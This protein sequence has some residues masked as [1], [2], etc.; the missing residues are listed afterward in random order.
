MVGATLACA[1][2]G[3]S[4]KVGVIEPQI[5]LPVQTQPDSRVSAITPAS[6]TVFEN[7]GAWIGINAARCGTIEAMHIWEGDSAVHFDSAEIGEPCLGWIVENRL[8]VSTLQERLQQ[9]SNIS[10]FCPAKLDQ[11]EIADKEVTVKLA[12]GR[13]L[14]AALLVGAD[15]ASSQVR[16]AVGIAWTSHDLAQAAI[17]ATLQT[18]QVHAGTARQRFLP[19]GPLA[20]LPLADPHHVSIVWSA[21][22]ALAH[23]LMVLD[24]AGFT[25][26]L[27]SAFG[28]S[29]GALRL[30]SERVVIPLTLGFAH[31]Y[32]SHRVALI[33]DAAHTVHPLAGQGVNL[34]I[35]D[36]ATLAEILLA[37]AVRRRDLGG[38]SLLRRYERARKGADLGMQLLT[39][40][41]RYLFGSNL[42]GSGRLRATGLGLSER[43]PVLKNFLMRRASGLGGELP[44]LAQRR[45]G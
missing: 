4:L 34:G 14:R 24:V 7:I 41:L 31:D 16:R 17:V 18:E 35:L 26:Q 12:D 21:D 40:G 10:L 23:E 29:L 27:Q 13:R 9:F 39:G 19:T 6:R 38:Q 3:S 43:L 33:G 8:L 36:A 45:H 15:G 1:L 37:G 11:V 30:V 20:L 5:A 42:P 28:D 22:S 44:R 32:S 25:T 2:G